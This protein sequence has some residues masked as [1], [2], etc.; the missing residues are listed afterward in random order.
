MLLSFVKA[1]SKADIASVAALADEIWH[2]HYKAILPADQID[3]MVKQFQSPSAIAAQIRGGYEYNL[4]VCDGTPVGY[5]GFNVENDRLFLS[6]LYILKEHRGHRHASNSLA[7]LAE[8]CIA[9]KLNTIWLTVNRY[10]TD[11][12]AVYRKMGF[13]VV[14][15]QI[16]DIGNGYVMDDYVMEMNFEP[17]PE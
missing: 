5:L 16:S 4:L 13:Q 8:R 10:N 7:F 15:S 2:E 11:S 6:K 12:I 17:R 1:E 14:R 9:R 3:Y